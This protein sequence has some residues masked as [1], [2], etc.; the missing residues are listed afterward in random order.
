MRQEVLL[1]L[2]CDSSTLA[3]IFSRSAAATICVAADPRLEKP[4]G[5]PGSKA[6]RFSRR[7]WFEVGIPDGGEDARHVETYRRPHIPAAGRDA[8][9]RSEGSTPWHSY[10][11][12]TD[13][14]SFHCIATTP[15]TRTGSS[16]SRRTRSSGR[17]ENHCGSLTPRASARS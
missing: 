13:A 14:I 1:W 16:F 7:K 9:S 4:T 11:A 6:G 17:I 3:D 12:R 10:D 8:V 5:V 2:T 15:R